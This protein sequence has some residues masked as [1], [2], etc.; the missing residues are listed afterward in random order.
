MSLIL[1]LAFGCLLTLGANAN[2]WAK[3]S[4][5]TLAQV[6][7]W[8]VDSAG[9]GLKRPTLAWRRMRRAGWAP[10]VKLGWLSG[11]DR[12]SRS[13]LKV[14]FDEL[15][16][17]GSTTQSTRLDS[18]VEVTVR[19]R[20]DELVSHPREV[21]LLR[22]LRQAAAARLEVLERVTR[23]YFDW[24]DARQIRLSDSTNDL[25]YRRLTRRVRRLAG[26]LD[27]LTSGRFSK[28]KTH[29]EGS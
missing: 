22:E 15:D 29:K 17:D 3:G 25:K 5:P 4:G 24:L 23:L 27:A 2:V 20:F 26:Q 16:G 12:T 7:T 8:A 10:E 14:T 9:V 1:G 13:Q 18:R 6:Q 19:W 28:G 21:T 11:E